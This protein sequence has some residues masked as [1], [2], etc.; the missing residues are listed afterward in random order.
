MGLSPPDPRSLC[1]LSSTEFVETP[2]PR[3]KF[4]GTPLDILCD[5]IVYCL[6]NIYETYMENFWLDIE[7][8]YGKNWIQIL[9]VL[10]LCVVWIKI[11]KDQVCEYV[12]E[13][14]IFI[15]IQKSMQKT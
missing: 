12:Q 8:I 3:T 13:T 10:V 7:Y 15:L 4:L 5:K 14:S 2:P 6:I 11:L 9:M 1:P